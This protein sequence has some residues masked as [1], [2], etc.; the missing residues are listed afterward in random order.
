MRFASLARG[1]YP[2]SWRSGYRRG[3][4]ARARAPTPRPDDIEA[5][6]VG[7][8]PPE[9]ETAVYFCCLEALQNAAKHGGP[10]RSDL[11]HVRR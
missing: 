6:G 8:Y 5:N 4:R 11:D 7:R 10:R 9:L 1:I 3:A 2:S